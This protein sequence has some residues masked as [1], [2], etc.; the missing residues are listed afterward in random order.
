MTFILNITNQDESRRLGIDT[1]Y[2]TMDYDA[3]NAF[4]RE[5]KYERIPRMFIAPLTELIDSE[6]PFEFVLYW[7]KYHIIL[8]TEEQPLEL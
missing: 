6:R 5:N 4:L 1:V 8:K 7:D 2:E 3:L